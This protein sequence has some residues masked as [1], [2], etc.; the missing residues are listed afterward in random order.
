[1][2]FPGQRNEHVS[3][4]VAPLR[5]IIRNQSTATD[6]PKTQEI[7]SRISDTSTP[8]DKPSEKVSIVKAYQ[9]IKA[10]VEKIVARINKQYNKIYIRLNDQ[11]DTLTTLNAQINTLNETIGRITTS[12]DRGNIYQ[13]HSPTVPST[14]FLKVCSPS[15]QI[16]IL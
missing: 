3:N 4:Q 12:I 11:C 10:K 2:I 14:I 7:K 15:T 16:P 6:F 9:Y 8:F 1:M 5:Y 13:S